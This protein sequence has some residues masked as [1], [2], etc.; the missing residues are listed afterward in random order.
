MPTK[1]SDKQQTIGALAADVGQA[2]AISG[3]SVT[4]SSPHKAATQRRSAA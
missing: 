2:K 3:D 4:V 1:D